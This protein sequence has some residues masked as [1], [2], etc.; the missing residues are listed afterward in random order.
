MWWLKKPGTLFCLCR[1]SFVSALWKAT[2]NNRV[3][4]LLNMQ[5]FPAKPRWSKVRT[6]CHIM[7]EERG[8]DTITTW[9]EKLCVGDA[10]RQFK[11]NLYFV[12]ASLIH[13]RTFVL[14]NNVFCIPISYPL[15]ERRKPRFQ[16]ISTYR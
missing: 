3:M 10:K 2:N 6:P 1:C 11:K 12:L 15:P 8:Y 9:K 14:T 16:L 4:F 7:R 5:D 13:I